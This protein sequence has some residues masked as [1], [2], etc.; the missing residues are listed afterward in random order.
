MRAK[1][2]LIKIPGADHSFRFKS[3]PGTPDQV[4]EDQ[5]QLAEELG[6]I[7]ADWWDGKDSAA[8]EAKLTWDKGAGKVVF[9]GWGPGDGGRT[10]VVTT[11]DVSGVKGS[12]GSS[13][14]VTKKLR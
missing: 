12:Y 5:N 14:S 1:S 7:A 8:T 10:M 2:W 9:S 6:R 13:W 3:I 4:R 11:F